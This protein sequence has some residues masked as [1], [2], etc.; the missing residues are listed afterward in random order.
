MGIV[1]FANLIDLLLLA[2]LLK[3]FRD[4]Q[5]TSIVVAF[6]AAPIISDRAILVL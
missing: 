1:D 6:S 5:S 2:F 4:L 3:K